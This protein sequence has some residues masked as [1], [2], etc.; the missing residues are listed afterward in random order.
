MDSK[1]PGGL[2]GTS[3][4]DSESDGFFLIAELFFAF[5]ERIC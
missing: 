2:L 1:V 5:S 3:V 4:S